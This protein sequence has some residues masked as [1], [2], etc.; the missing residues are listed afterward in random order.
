ME[1]GREREREGVQSRRRPKRCANREINLYI[2][3][4]GRFNRNRETVL[5]EVCKFHQRRSFSII[6]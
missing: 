5:R 3:G 4:R 1:R 6:H 2:R